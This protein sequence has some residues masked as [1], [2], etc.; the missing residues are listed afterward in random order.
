MTRQTREQTGRK[1]VGRRTSLILATS[2]PTSDS[3][4][5]SRRGRRRQVSRWVPRG[6][7]ET[8]C[9][10]SETKLANNCGEYGCGEKLMSTHVNALY[11][12]LDLDRLCR[13][14]RGRV[15]RTGIR[16]SRVLYSSNS[17]FIVDS[18][19]KYES[20]RISSSCPRAPRPP[21]ASAVQSE[22]PPHKHSISGPFSCM[23]QNYRP[24][25]IPHRNSE[26]IGIQKS[27]IRILSA[28][29]QSVMMSHSEFQKYAEFQ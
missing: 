14:C 5:R 20:F 3:R 22:S 15:A 21:V 24:R 7:A 17:V 12:D 13:R 11:L 19:I 10:V 9:D 6:R 2:W 28:I 26:I 1:M 27:E 4:G 8:V 18:S 23:K 25:A 29:S 16:L